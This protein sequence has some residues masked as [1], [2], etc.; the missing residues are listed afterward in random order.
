[1]LEAPCPLSTHQS[2]KEI[3]MSAL[4]H[5]ISPAPIR[6]V[7]GEPYHSRFWNSI[8]Q[9]TGCWW[10]MGSLTKDGYGQFHLGAQNRPRAALRAHRLAYEMLIGPI[11]EGL[12]LDHL[13]CY[14]RCV[15]PAHLEP[16]TLQENFK[17]GGA[18]ISKTHCP[19]GHAYDTHNTRYRGYRIRGRRGVGRICKACDREAQKRYRT[20]KAKKTPRCQPL[21]LS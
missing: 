4:Q 16:V 15:N 8:L 13:C 6:T 20:L 12:V 3:G 14:K 17:R 7:L 1:M 2:A 5:T 9:T 19:Y 10:W 11:P 18:N 21:H